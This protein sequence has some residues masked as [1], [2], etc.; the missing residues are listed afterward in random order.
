M[1]EA[2]AGN[3]AT[4][5]ITR[6]WKD[7]G[8]SFSRAEL[9]RAARFWITNGRQA[10]TEYFAELLRRFDPEAARLY[11]NACAAHRALADHFVQ[12]LEDYQ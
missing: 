5:L 3:A 7:H 12:R 9:V 11:A 1:H 2:K 10:D 6:I 8:L 4:S